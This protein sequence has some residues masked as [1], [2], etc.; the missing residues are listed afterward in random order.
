[1]DPRHWISFARGARLGGDVAAEINVEFAG[2]TEVI[3]RPR[4][5]HGVA[6]GH[7][8]TARDGDKR[9]GFRRFAGCFHG[10]QVHTRERAD[11]PEVTG[12]FCAVRACEM[13]CQCDGFSADDE[14]HQPESGRFSGGVPFM[15][16]SLFSFPATPVP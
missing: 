2:D 16:L 7:A 12:F 8:A 3:R 5:A 6:E 11:H 10:L 14:D 4:V 13:R 9:I 15:R 1:M